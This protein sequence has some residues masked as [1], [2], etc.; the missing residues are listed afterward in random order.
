M[1]ARSRSSLHDHRRSQPL[2]RWHAAVIHHI[3]LL[4]MAIRSK[5]RMT[6]R[7]RH[8][9]RA[10]RRPPPPLPI[11]TACAA[12]PRRATTHPRERSDHSGSDQ[13]SGTC[14]RRQPDETW[15]PRPGP[16]ALLGALGDSA[17]PGGCACLLALFIP[18]G[19]GLGLSAP[20]TYVNKE[21]L[22][23]ARPLAS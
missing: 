15:R 14:G 11:A 19:P 4:A 1:W 8:G 17:W 3:G 12:A 22:A 20:A 9:R 2:A 21:R 6:C 7:S 16:A 5:P 13:L 23:T 10:R 18:A